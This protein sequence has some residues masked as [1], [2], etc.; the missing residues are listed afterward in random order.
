MFRFT[1]DPDAKRIYYRS[2]MHD[3]CPLSDEDHS[4]WVSVNE[5]TDVVPNDQTFFVL[6]SKFSESSD[7]Y[8]VSVGFVAYCLTLECAR[9][10]MGDFIAQNA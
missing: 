8:P 5:V 9:R 2:D 3:L 10:C 1:A 4:V 7:D 6:V